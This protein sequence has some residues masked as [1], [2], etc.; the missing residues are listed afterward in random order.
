VATWGGNLSESELVLLVYD[1]LMRGDE[2]TEKMLL[3][4]Q[5]TSIYPEEV[6]AA[7]K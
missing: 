5:G 2:T 7:I 4:Q 3:E 6:P 1:H